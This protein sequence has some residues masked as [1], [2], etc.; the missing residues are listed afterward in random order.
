[1]S[2][3]QKIDFITNRLKKVDDHFLEIVHAMFQKEAELNDDEIIGYDID[4]KPISTE[5][6][7][8]IFEKGVQEVKNGGG[9]TVDQLR[10]EAESW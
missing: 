3:A 2:N 5:E 6:A 1:M 4:G 8:E 9:Y 7:E 10:K